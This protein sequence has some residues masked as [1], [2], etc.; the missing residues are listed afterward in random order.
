MPRA[1]RR[2]IDKEMQD[3]LRD[4]FAYLISALHRSKEIE[5]FLEDFLT[6]EEKTMLS[7]RLMLHLML[8]N[9]YKSSEI[10]AVLGV[11]HETIRVHKEIWSR[12]GEAYRKMIRKIAKREK[13]KEFWQKVEKILKPLEYA[14]QAKTNM[15]ARSKLLNYPWEEK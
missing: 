11:S 7:K 10:E 12:G 13:T 4:N 14:F 8:E 3:E 9:G 2:E 15:K 6:H 1:S 5:N